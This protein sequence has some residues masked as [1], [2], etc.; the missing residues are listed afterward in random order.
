MNEAPSSRSQKARFQGLF[1]FVWL[2][3]GLIGTPVWTDAA[4]S[5]EELKILN[6]SDNRMMAARKKIISESLDLTP[7]EA[8]AFW[9]VYELYLQELTKLDD[10]RRNILSDYGEN[11]DNVSDE[12]AERFLIS[13]MK[14]RQD[15]YRIMMEFI[16]KFERVLPM[17]K[18][19]RYYHIELKIR[20]FI[21]A[22][23]EEELPL[24]R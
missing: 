15:R 18:L 16:P 12:D 8:K 5:S 7:E 1:L 9:P 23:I 13:R 24:I 19:A 2:W 6:E 14:L 4:P 17:K 3:L 10:R 20:S 11:Y 22:G 21:D